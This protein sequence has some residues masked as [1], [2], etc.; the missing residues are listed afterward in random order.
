MEEKA[1]E[2]KDFFDELYELDQAE[3]DSEEINA[4]ALILRRSRK[5]VSKTN[6]AVT[7]HPRDD[8]LKQGQISAPP[9]NYITRTVSA[10][11]P[12][13]HTP[14]SRNVEFVKDTPAAIVKTTVHQ[15]A[16]SSQESKAEFSRNTLGGKPTEPSKMPAKRKRGKSLQLVPQSQQIFRGLQFCT[17]MSST[18]GAVLTLLSLCTQQRHCTGSEDE[19]YQ[20]FGI[21]SLMDQG[22]E[23]WDHSCHCG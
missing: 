18:Y 20:G 10:P 17:L 12:L 5:A 19:D 7:P 2:K 23:R 1:R 9:P 14:L 8:V 3:E 4:A 16:A 15:G 11:L 22:L 13:V 21:W 6:V